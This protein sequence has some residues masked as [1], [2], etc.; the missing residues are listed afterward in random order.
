[1]GNTTGRLLAGTREMTAC[2]IARKPTWSQTSPGNNCPEPDV[3]LQKYEILLSLTKPKGFLIC[4]SVRTDAVSGF[5]QTH[6][7]GFVKGNICTSKRSMLVQ[8]ALEIVCK[9]TK[10]DSPSIRECVFLQVPPEVIGTQELE[11]D[12]TGAP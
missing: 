2:C 9:R 10:S 12:R 1:M 6:V 3:S 8:Y 5:L 11:L 4:A 7:H